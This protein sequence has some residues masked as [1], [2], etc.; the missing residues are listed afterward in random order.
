MFDWNDLKF[1]LAVARAGSTLAASRSLKVSQATVSRRITLFE[2]GLGVEL[3]ARHASG[4]VPTARGEALLPLAEAVE[5]EV[6]RFAAGLAAESRRLSGRVKLTT[7]ES[8]VSAW[9]IPALA[10]LR[11]TH[12]GIEV[13]V[14][15][16]DTNLDLASGEADIAIRFGHQPTGDTLILR[17][18][19]ELEETV[20]ASRELVTRLGRPA[21][22]ADLARYPLVADGID[23]ASRF[24]G[25]LEREVPDGRVVQ[26]VNSISGILASVKTG[27]GAAL[28]PCIIGDDV[29]SLVRLM[30]PIPE[31]TTPCWLVTTDQARRQ[32]HVR[33]T[34]DAVIGNIEQVSARIGPRG[35]D[36]ALTG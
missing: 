27:I 16:T 9:V 17:R 15:G 22:P 36:E 28:L 30:P 32:P 14:I 3:F 33:A 7:V 18:L 8:A 25:W 24:S 23:R 19:T 4:Y 11:E 13:E 35:D 2:E 5:S 20:Y 12:P 31:L 21:S 6:M 1:F 29:R 26:R 10:A 34:I